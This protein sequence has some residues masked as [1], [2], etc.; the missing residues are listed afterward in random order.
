MPSPPQSTFV[1]DAV[2]QPR[3][4]KQ[5]LLEVAQILTVRSFEELASLLSS[6]I[7]ISGS[8]EMDVINFLWPLSGKP[9]YFPVNASQRSRLLSIPPLASVFPSG[10]KATK[11]THP[12]WPSQVTSGLSVFRS[13]SL[14]VVSPE[15]EASLEPSGENATY[16]IASEWPS[17]VLDA[18]VTGLILNIASGLN[19]SGSTISALNKSFC[20]SR[21]SWTNVLISRSPK[22]N[23]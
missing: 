9:I 21:L 6:V 12:L 22:K 13:Q 19:V 8:Q 17:K 11:S 3:V 2:W 7:L 15:A 4:L 23:W 16:R 10:E 14:T 18:L 20:L 5:L 1:T